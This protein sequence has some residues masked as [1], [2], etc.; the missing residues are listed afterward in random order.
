VTTAILGQNGQP[1]LR[2]GSNSPRLEARLELLEA[3]CS[4]AARAGLDSSRESCLPARGS[5]AHP[6]SA[7]EPREPPNRE[8]KAG[9]APREKQRQ[10]G[11]F[12]HSFKV[13][14]K[15]AAATA[16]KFGL[17]AHWSG[18]N[19]PRDGP[20][21]RASAPDWTAPSRRDRARGARN[22]NCPGRAGA[23]AWRASAR[24]CG[25]GERRSTDCNRYI[26]PT[27]GAV[28]SGKVTGQSARRRARKK[29]SPPRYGGTI[30]GA[31]LPSSR[32]SQRRP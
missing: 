30:L 24:R 10:D 32:S 13:K 19:R 11:R 21:P 4:A 23:N 29:R 16:A 14:E 9:P 25:P 27:N 31:A 7:T 20:S 26:G 28:L 3:T 22:S 17:A 2:A 6:S 5:S 1:R 18:G 8:A 12:R 15:V